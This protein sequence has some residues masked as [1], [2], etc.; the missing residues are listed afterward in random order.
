MIEYPM[1]F[2]AGL[3]GASHCVGMCGGFAMMLGLSARTPW[4]NVGAQLI[5]SSGR[6]FTYSVLGCLAGYFGGQLTQDWALWLNVPAVLSLVAGLFL[7]Y[8]GLH[9]AGISLWRGNS[10]T[11]A[12]NGCL[13]GPLFKTFFMSTRPTQQFLAGVLTGFL[14]CGLLYGALALAASTGNLLTG[15]MVM[16]L[17]G[18]GTV[19]LMLLTGVGGSLLSLASRTR[20]LRMA[21]WCVVLTGALTIARGAGFIRIPGLISASG[22]PMCI[23][24]P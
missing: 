2:L 8:Q 5:Y 7:I 18:A 23:E 16:L 11:T 4:R 3:L 20:L 13:A 24:K 19:P 15:G 12:S 14:P 17:F 6:L 1:I 22:C 9:A 21:A 10:R